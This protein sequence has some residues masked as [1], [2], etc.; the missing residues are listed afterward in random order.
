MD[1]WVKWLLMIFSILLCIDVYKHEK[2][3]K[4]NERK[5]NPAYKIWIMK[6][7]LHTQN[8]NQEEMKKQKKVHMW[9]LLKEDDD[10]GSTFKKRFSITY[11]AVGS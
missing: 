2:M 3:K 4:M 8:V 11:R 7:K 9:P 10:K 1:D 5:K 6:K